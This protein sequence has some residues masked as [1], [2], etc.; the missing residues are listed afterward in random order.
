MQKT[1][2]FSDFYCLPDKLA[3]MGL[4]PVIFGPRTPHGTPGRVVRTG[5]RPGV[6]GRFHLGGQQRDLLKPQISPLRYAPVE[7]TNLLHGKCLISSQRTAWRDLRFSL[8]PVWVLAA[9]DHAGLHYEG[10]VLE[11]ADV[12]ERIAGHGNDVGIVAG[13]EGA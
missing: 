2:V 1:T 13:F 8:T 3:L 9:V 12:V 11:Y 4:R 6:E 5:T 7:M 10:D